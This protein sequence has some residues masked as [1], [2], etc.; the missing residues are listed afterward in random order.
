MTRENCRPIAIVADVA[1]MSIVSRVG[2]AR[3]EKVTEISAIGFICPDSGR[4]L[5]ADCFTRCRIADQ[6]PAGR[7]MALRNLK[8]IADQRP[9]YLD[10]PEWK[11]SCTLLLKGIREAY[12]S[13]VKDYYIDPQD[14]IFRIVGT[15]AHSELDKY[16]GEN[17]SGEIRLE[18]EGITGQYDYLD[19][20]GTLFDTKTSSSYKIMSW[21]GIKSV[22]VPTGEVYKTDCKSGR[23]GDPKYR[24][25]FVQGEPELREQT[26]QLNLYR[27]MLERIGTLI[28]RMFLDVVV[29]DGGLKVAS[30]RGVEQN[31]YLIPIPHLPDDE[32]L[33]YFIP[34]RDALLWHLQTS[35]MPEVC[36][37]D[38]RWSDGKCLRYCN[39]A[40]FCDYGN[41]LKGGVICQE[42]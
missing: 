2:L 33:G 36:S 6:F 29:R 14:A 28:K 8:M 26:L 40:E 27:M 25:E 4:C 3:R 32:V 16:T 34:K 22:D 7:C 13:Q 23:K 1:L 9:T 24:K 42:Q 21:L 15:K 19:E 38:E 35:T 17:E 30:T 12:L 18:I 39:V 41:A 20:E 37:F 5:F 11:P 10:D 31:S